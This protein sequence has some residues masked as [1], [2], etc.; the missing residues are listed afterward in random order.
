MSPSSTI[1][2]II[3]KS[4]LPCGHR[5]RCTTRSRFFQPRVSRA[6]RCL[7]A[8]RNSQECDESEIPTI[9]FRFRLARDD[10]ESRRRPSITSLASFVSRCGSLGT[11]GSNVK[12]FT[13]LVS[14]GIL[15]SVSAALDSAEIFSHLACNISQI[16]QCVFLWMFAK[17]WIS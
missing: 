7:F 6:A 15:S 10:N 3:Y 4:R 2:H 11:F 13:Q 16:D 1:P 12:H 17:N 9:S 8:C 14:T 5:V